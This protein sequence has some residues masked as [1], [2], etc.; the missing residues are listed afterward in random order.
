MI[1]AVSLTLPQQKDRYFGE[2]H[3]P[4]LWRCKNVLWRTKVWDRRAVRL[5]HREAF[6]PR[7]LT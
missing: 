7:A 6:S 4:L 2:D 5:V 1:L 3:T